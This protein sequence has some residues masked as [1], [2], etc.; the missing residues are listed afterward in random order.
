MVLR[1]LPEVPIVVVPGDPEN[2][3][4]TEPLDLF[5]AEQLLRRRAEYPD[6]ADSVHVSCGS[7]AQVANWVSL[8]KLTC[9]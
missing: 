9:T 8:V 3:K 1:Y 7:D 6:P 4:I 5:L 2:L